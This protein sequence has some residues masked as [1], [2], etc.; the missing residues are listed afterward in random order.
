MVDLFDLKAARAEITPI[1][2]KVWRHCESKGL[3]GR[4]VTLKVKYTDFQI[5]TRSRTMTNPI[6]TAD[7]LEGVSQ[8]LLEP[9][10][11]TAKGVR[12]LGITVSSFIDDEVSEA[13]QLE[14]QI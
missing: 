5:I 7:D 8:S 13:N 4:T 2:A 11:P 9:L 10:F 12:L 3:N 1:A 6:G 14:L